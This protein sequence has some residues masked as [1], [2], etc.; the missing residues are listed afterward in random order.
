MSLTQVRVWWKR[1]HSGQVSTKDN[2]KTGRPRSKRT[3]PNT[4]V[5]EGLIANDNRRSIRGLSTASGL[6]RGTVWNIVKKDLKMRHRSARLVPHML[7][8]EQKAFRKRLCEENLTLTRADP[9]EFLAKIVTTDETW[10]ATFEPKTK[11]Q[12]SAWILPDQNAP[13]KARRQRGQRKA[14]MYAVRAI[15]EFPLVPAIF[16][17]LPIHR[18][19]L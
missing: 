1:F 19:Q 8:P 9:A 11:R 4:Q 5:I 2:P 17:V 3:R 16:R 7:T 14:M 6:S 12:S 10:I 13:Q 15:K 18:S